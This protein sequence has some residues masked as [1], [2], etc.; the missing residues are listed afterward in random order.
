MYTL[1]HASS[2]IRLKIVLW[3]VLRYELTRDVDQ[4]DELFALL[5]IEWECGDRRSENVF[6][7]ISISAIVTKYSMHELDRTSSSVAQATE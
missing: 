6:R 1:S 7:R 4:L 5:C 3:L 2:E